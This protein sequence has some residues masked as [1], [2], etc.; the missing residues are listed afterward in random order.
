[1]GERRLVFFALRIVSRFQARAI[2]D[3]AAAAGAAYL[4][5]WPWSF[6]VCRGA[7]LPGIANPTLPSGSSDD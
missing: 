5:Y 3:A 2:I 6:V 1:V 7:P 4:V